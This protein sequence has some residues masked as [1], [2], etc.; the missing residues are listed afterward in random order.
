MKKYGMIFATVI[1][2]LLII[3]IPNQKINAEKLESKT[4]NYDNYSNFINNYGEQMEEIRLYLEEI[5]TYKYFIVASPSTNTFFVKLYTSQNILAYITLDNSSSTLIFNHQ[6]INMNNIYIEFGSKYDFQTQFN[7]LKTKINNKEYDVSKYGSSYSATYNSSNDIRNTFNFM[8]ATNFNYTLSS[9]S[10]YNLQLGGTIVEPT[11]PIPTYYDYIYGKKINIESSYICDVEG[12]DAE[13]V[14]IDFSQYS[15]ID[16][17]YQYGIKR[18]VNSNIVWFNLDVLNNY[19]YSFNEYYTNTT[20]YARVLDNNNN[21]IAISEYA[22]LNDLLPNFEMKITSSLACP[23]PNYENDPLAEIIQ[24]DLTNCYDNDYFYEYSYDGKTYHK[25]NVNSSEKIYYLNDYLGLHITFRIVDKNN[26][27]V[28]FTYGNRTNDFISNYDF[29]RGKVYFKESIAN[30][31]EGNKVIVL[32][33]DFRNVTTFVNEYNFDVVIDGV[34]Y[35]EIQYKEIIL[36]RENY[37]QFYDVKIYIDKEVYHKEI[38]KLAKLSD[39]LDFDSMYDKIQNND[40]GNLDL[41][42]ED[43]ASMKDLYIAFLTAISSFIATFFDLLFYAFESLN[44]WIRACILC[45]FIE[46]IITRIIKV[47]RKR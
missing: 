17:K 22:I 32:T 27:L 29:D 28:Y 16:Y 8:Y 14:T 31:L 13:Y 7:T 19:I 20:I 30:D 5:G 47:A 38:Y 46:Y 6:N 12:K 18:H 37:Q 40:V 2:T 9:D 43:V 36:T 3:L 10:I 24:I 45:L 11:E 23:I 26:N 42:V 33:M 39:E 41:N 34:S 4:L 21:E 25:L 1:F 15:S 35:G 44:I